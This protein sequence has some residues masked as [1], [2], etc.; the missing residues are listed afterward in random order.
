MTYELTNQEKISVVNQHLKNLEYSAF[1]LSLSVIEEEAATIPNAENISNL[2]LQIAEV[3]AKKTALLAEL[4][5]LG[6]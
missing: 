6:A 4:E 3:N 5:E 2:N 1:N